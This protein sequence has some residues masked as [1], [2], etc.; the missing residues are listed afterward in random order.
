MK[1]AL[2]ISTFLL[3]FLS[4]GKWAYSQ[5]APLPEV[6]LK[7]QEKAIVDQ[8]VM[9]PMRDGIRLC[10]DIYRPKTDQPVPVISCAHLTISIP[11]RTEK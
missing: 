2:R 7:L 4:F 6:W 1:Q 11:G 10:T 3:L 9:M 8:K 5:E